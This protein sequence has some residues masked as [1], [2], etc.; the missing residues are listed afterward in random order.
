MSL[1]DK[2]I[3]RYRIQSWKWRCGYRPGD[4]ACIYRYFMP[5]QTHN[6]FTF[7]ISINDNNNMIVE[8]QQHAK[9]RVYDNDNN[10]LYISI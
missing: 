4:R 8:T 1:L 6:T 5:L 2:I 10:N 3:N 9:C 7:G